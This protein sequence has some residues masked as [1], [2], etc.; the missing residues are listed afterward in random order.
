MTAKPTTSR[1][2]SRFRKVWICVSS[3]IGVSSVLDQRYVGPARRNSP[4]R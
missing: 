4:N 2:E 3:I 1:G